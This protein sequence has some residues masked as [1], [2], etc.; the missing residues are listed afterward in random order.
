VLD[1][2][3]RLLT[4]STLYPSAVRPAT[5]I[6]S[7]PGCVISSRRLRASV[8]VHQSHGSHHRIRHWSLR[9]VR[10][11][12]RRKRI[13]TSKCCTRAIRFREDRHDGPRV[14]A[15]RSV[16]GT[17]AQGPT[18]RLSVD[19]MMRLLLSGRRRRHA[20]RPTLGS[21]LVITARG[22]DINEIAQHTIPRRSI[23]WAARRADGVI[24][25]VRH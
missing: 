15:R 18:P 7:R 22:S 16:R 10:G 8:V 5:G 3:L 21:R 25:V 9:S 6:S 23:C 24:A 11:T 1:R 4:F 19:A 17:S 13:T 20:A 2:R 12:P 14:S